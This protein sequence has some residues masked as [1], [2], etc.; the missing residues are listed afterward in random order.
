MNNK[1]RDAVF[2]LYRTT[3]DMLEVYKLIDERKNADTAPLQDGL[4]VYGNT[5]AKWCEKYLEV[6]KCADV[7]S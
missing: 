1:K 6:A 2:A 4:K 7:K 5:L 3:K